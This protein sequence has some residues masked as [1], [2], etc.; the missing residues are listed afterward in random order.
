MSDRN[1]IT[2]RTPDRLEHRKHDDYRHHP[3]QSFPAKQADTKKQIF[4]NF[5]NFEFGKDLR[6]I[7]IKTNLLSVVKLLHF[8]SWPYPRFLRNILH[9][10]TEKNR[11]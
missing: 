4:L 7:F 1:C 3:R 5:L 9:P 10:G 8:V 6:N 2:Y 11:R